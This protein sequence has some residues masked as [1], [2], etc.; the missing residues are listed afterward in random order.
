[1][2]VIAKT[3][4]TSKISLALLIYLVD[5]TVNESSKIFGEICL[6]SSRVFRTPYIG[7]SKNEKF[8]ICIYAVYQVHE[9]SRRIEGISWM[10]MNE[11]E[12]GR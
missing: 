12:Y 3:L 8:E 11:V 5:M 10:C 6:Y 2:G 4:W 1:M 9:T 7:R